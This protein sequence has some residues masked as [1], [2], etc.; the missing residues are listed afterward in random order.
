MGE[1]CAEACASPGRCTCTRFPPRH[2]PLRKTTEVCEGP[3]FFPRRLS[4]KPPP[5]LPDHPDHRLLN[6][7]SRLKRSNKLPFFYHALPPCAGHPCCYLLFVSLPRAGTE[8]QQRASPSRLSLASSDTVFY[9]LTFQC[10]ITKEGRKR[11]TRKGR[12][13][14]AFSY[15]ISGSSYSLWRAHSLSLS[16]SPLCDVAFAVWISLWGKVQKRSARN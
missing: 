3:L 8:R 14:R 7:L 16:L 10:K 12:L 1:G 15:F 9:L 5:H 13:T 2:I 6:G 4:P 11:W